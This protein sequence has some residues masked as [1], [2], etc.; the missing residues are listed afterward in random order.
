MS[1]SPVVPTH[2]GR[3]VKKTIGLDAI[4]NGTEHDSLNRSPQIKD[5]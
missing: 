4:R 3:F 1:R 2:G 5:R